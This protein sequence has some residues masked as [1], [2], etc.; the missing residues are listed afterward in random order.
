MIKD[1]LSNFN[2][3]VIVRWRLPSGEWSIKGTTVK[4]ITMKFYFLLVLIQEK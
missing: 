3:K 2:K 1:E 4:A